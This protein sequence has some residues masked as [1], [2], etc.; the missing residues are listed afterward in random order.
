M[1]NNSLYIE[2]GKHPRKC[3][4]ENDSLAKRQKVNAVFNDLFTLFEINLFA[5]ERWRF[6]YLIRKP[7]G[8]GC[9]LIIAYYNLTAVLLERT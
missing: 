5:R 7:Y 1:P 4:V 2:T 6:I 3:P 9:S 8:A